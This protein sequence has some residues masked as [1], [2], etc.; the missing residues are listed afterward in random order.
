M[1]GRH[2]P[3]ALCCALCKC[4]ACGGARPQGAARVRACVLCMYTHGLPACKWA[5]GW[6]PARWGGGGYRLKGGTAACIA[7]PG[8]GTAGAHAL[9]Q[10]PLAQKLRSPPP[11][12]TVV[13]VQDHSQGRCGCFERRSTVPTTALRP[14]PPF[15]RLSASTDTGEAGENWP[16]A[17]VYFGPPPAVGVPAAVASGSGRSGDPRLSARAPRSRRPYAPGAIEK[18]Y[19]A[20]S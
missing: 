10:L 19:S 16:S 20:P 15:P 18:S 12:P 6:R 3:P 17:A 8:A 13:P 11:K 5:I 2:C 1:S 4:A 9:A 7:A 14:K